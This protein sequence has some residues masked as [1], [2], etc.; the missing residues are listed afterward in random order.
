MSHSRKPCPYTYRPCFARLAPKRIVL[1]MLWA[2]SL[3]D[4]RLGPVLA[5]DQGPLTPVWSPD[6]KQLAYARDAPTSDESQISIWSLDT[7]TERLL[8]AP[9][10][11]GKLPYDWSPDGRELLIARGTE[12]N[13]RAEIWSVPISDWRED[14]ERKI[15]GESG[16]DLY[17]P[18]FSPDKRW[19]VF[20]AEKGGDSAL[21]VIPA[22]GGR[23]IPIPP[24]GHWDDKPRWSPDGKTIYYVSETHGLFNVWGI[25]FNSI[26]GIAAGKPFQ[27][28]K[29]D[30]PNLMIPAYIPP[31]EL[32]IGKDKLVINLAEASGS[33]W[34]LENVR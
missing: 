18:H 9:S 13:S 33:I 16:Y 34:M 29:F 1:A 28:T 4:P 25:H 17:Q 12:N 31:V 8:T 3:T 23:W 15:A 5:T 21:Y 20:E 7:H 24:R 11:I 14:R 19:I 2:Q 10:A 26:R 30:S 27:V 32:S 22:D 6:G